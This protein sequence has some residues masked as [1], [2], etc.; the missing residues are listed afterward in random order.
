M[1]NVFM[2]VSDIA[3][4]VTD[5][6]SKA[7]CLAIEVENNFFDSIDITTKK[8]ADKAKYY[9]PKTH[10]QHRIIMDYLHIAN[11]QLQNI[12]QLINED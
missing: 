12:N 7:R 10:I 1:N 5:A 6:I 11:Q 8:G 2:Q 9:F 4:T 3:A